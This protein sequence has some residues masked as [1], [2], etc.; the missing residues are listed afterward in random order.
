[1]SE[2]PERTLSS[3]L[4][5]GTKQEITYYTREW[6]RQVGN[7]S[8]PSDQHLHATAA[9]KAI[10]A[11]G[12]KEVF[13][14]LAFEANKIVVGF[15]RFVDPL[16]AL[17]GALESARYYGHVMALLPLISAMNGYLDSPQRGTTL[18]G[19]AVKLG[20]SILEA[21][22]SN[23]SKRPDGGAGVEFIFDYFTQVEKRLG[24]RKT[25]Y[26]Q[27]SSPEPR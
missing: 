15:A 10:N 9:L 21:D 26:V 23:N 16:Q 20:F 7:L 25:I 17:S 1:M 12:K 24:E 3:V 6:E 11:S 8:A 5:S 2:N 4:L 22:K 13:G 14:D 19:N 18:A 27:N